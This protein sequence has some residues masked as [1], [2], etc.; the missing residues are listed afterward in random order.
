MMPNTWGCC[1]K[2]K[3]FVGQPLFVYIIF[4]INIRILFHFSYCFTPNSYGIIILNI[5]EYTLPASPQGGVDP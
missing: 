1:T 4:L 5:S 2:L 3:N